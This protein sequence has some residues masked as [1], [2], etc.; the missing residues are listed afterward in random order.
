MGGE[1]RVGERERVEGGRD[2]ARE[3]GVMI[4]TTTDN[5]QR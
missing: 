5:A 4:M 2:G 1:G 3:R